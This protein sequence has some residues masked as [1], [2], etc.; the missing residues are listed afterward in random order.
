M[1]EMQLSKVFLQLTLSVNS[2]IYASGHFDQTNSLALLAIT[3]N[4]SCTHTGLDNHGISHIERR[5][6]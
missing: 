3:E 4:P 5:L 6:Q 1:T 2:D